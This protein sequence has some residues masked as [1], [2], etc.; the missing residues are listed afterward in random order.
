MHIILIRQLPVG[1]LA[2]INNDWVDMTE[3]HS[4]INNV[5]VNIVF[6]TPKPDCDISN[7]IISHEQYSLWCNDLFSFNCGFSLK[8]VDFNE[9][10]VSNVVRGEEICINYLVMDNLSEIKKWQYSLLRW[11]F[12]SEWCMLFH[13]VLTCF[14]WMN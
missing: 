3:V 9:S 1:G 12:V 8:T 6:S 4:S 5:L 10:I 14:N 2:N 13:D 11:L 7:W